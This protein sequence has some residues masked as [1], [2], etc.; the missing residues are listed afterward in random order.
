MAL[1]AY[2]VIRRAL[3]KCGA[4][5]PSQPLNSQEASDG[6]QMLNIM[7]S[8]WF[9]NSYIKQKDEL[10][11][12]ITLETDKI[13][14]GVNPYNTCCNEEEA[15]KHISDINPLQ[16]LNLFYRDDNGIY[17][18]NEIEMVNRIDTEKYRVN[19]AST[20]WPAMASYQ[21]GDLT[22]TSYLHFSMLVTPTLNLKMFYL[23]PH[24][25]IEEADL[26]FALNLPSQ[27][28]NTIIL[29]LSSR[30]AA[31]Y[32][33]QLSAIDMMQLEKSRRELMNLRS[34]PIPFASFDSGVST[35]GR[36]ANRNGATV[37]FYTRPF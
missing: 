15:A 31:D 9:M 14:F 16:I 7:L 11:F 4:I 35:M 29:D 13:S 27:H 10:D 19:S 24:V 20:R 6:L 26:H 30:L 21:Y 5:D 33:G 3:M 36:N 8:E 2:D 18:S 28:Y 1:T 23:R 12:S 25:D 22:G 32:G 37:P 17:L 34:S